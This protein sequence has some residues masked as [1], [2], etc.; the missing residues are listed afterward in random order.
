MRDQ[1]RISGAG[2]DMDDGKDGDGGRGGEPQESEDIP[3]HLL[4]RIRELEREIEHLRDE[5]KDLEDRNGHLE[6]RNS[7]LED[8]NSHLEDR[9]SHL[10]DRN[11][12]LEDRN[13]ELEKENETLKIIIRTMEGKLD[14]ALETG[15]ELERRV[16][17]NSS[18]SSKP[19]SS[20][21]YRKPRPRSLRTR[22]GRRRGGQPGH[23]GHAVA[24]PHGPDAVETH[25]PDLC[26]GCPRLEACKAGEMS[27]QGSRYL[28]DIEMYA[29]VTE[30]VV[31]GHESCPVAGG[32]VVGSFPDGVRAHIQYGDSVVKLAGILSTYGA[33]SCERISELMR[34]LFRISISRGT[35]LHMV[36]RCSEKV[37]GTL[38][39]V[40]RRIAASPVSHHDETGV[41]VDGKLSCVHSSST[42]EFTY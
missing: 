28:I 31:L 37:S 24:L 38:E 33:V 13:R 11:S 18:N 40:R 9:N 19:P 26:T 20:D 21:G 32:P 36:S 1:P 17:L 15:K 34:D 3:D 42:G 41:R 27:C 2:D 7:H 14:S 16:G 8:R 10:E 5:N 29:K 23:E 25:L 35:V 6:D 4:E 22:S 30:H 12:H 39:E